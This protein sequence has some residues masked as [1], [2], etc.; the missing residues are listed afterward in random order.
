MS[1]PLTSEQVNYLVWRYLQES[2]TDPNYYMHEEKKIPMSRKYIG[3]YCTSHISDSFEKSTFSFQDDCKAQVLEDK[4]KAWIKPGALIHIIQKGLQYLALEASIYENGTIG[5]GKVF[6]FFGPSK[7]QEEP[8]SG[9]A[10]VEVAMQDAAGDVE[11]SNGSAP[12]EET[13]GVSIELEAQRA[14]LLREPPQ[15]NGT[16]TPVKRGYDL[17]TA[18]LPPEINGA[19]GQRPKRAKTAAAD[20][21]AMVIDGIG[22]PDTTSEEVRATIGSSVGVQADEY[23]QLDHESSG[24][25]QLSSIFN[26][27][28]GASARNCKFSPADKNKIAVSLENCHLFDLG[29]NPFTPN[30]NIKEQELFQQFNIEMSTIAWGNNGEYLATASW[31]GLIK[32]WDSRGRSRQS[33]KMHAAPILSLKFHPTKSNLLLS[34]DSHTKVIV[35]DVITGK[36]IKMCELARTD[37]ASDG[38]GPH[39]PHDADWIDENTIIVV[40]DNGAVEKFDLSMPSEKGSHL[41]SVLKFEGHDTHKHVNSVVW[42]GGHEVFATGGEEGKILLWKPNQ[43]KPIAVLEGHQGEISSL[44]LFHGSTPS[45][46]LLGSASADG[47][48]RIWNIDSRICLHVLNMQSPVDV[49]SFTADGKYLAAGAQNLLV[50]I[51]LTETGQ[52]VGMYDAKQGDEGL[53]AENT[54]EDL[55]WDKEGARLAVAVKNQKCA[56]IDWRTLLNDAATKKAR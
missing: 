35:W 20:E 40:G 32:I 50:M 29:D 33:L 52:P 11:M 24:V 38:N 48:V 37:S 3:H 54:M 46:T 31:D 5:S 6:S 12:H 47:T 2:G 49:L 22:L 28:Q 26:A 7:L 39:T 14:E 21:N 23:I 27:S 17:A 34:V 56:I 8:T 44:Q 1:V 19:T 4:F 51:W 25:S 10:S 43:Q 15:T 41:E 55:S 45:V 42:S 30:G 13:N 53:S 18:T 16:V 9:P 36:L